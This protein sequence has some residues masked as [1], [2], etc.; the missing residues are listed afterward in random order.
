MASFEADLSGLGGGAAVVFASGFLT[1]SSNQDGEPF[2]I[3]AALAD[4]NV[5]E[6]PQITT[7]RLQVI[8]NAADPA[9]AS[10]DIYL[11]S[12]LL[13]D[14]FA[15]RA[16]SRFVT[17]PANVMLDV[18]VAPGSS[19]SVNDTLKN[20]PVMFAAGGTYVAIANGVL[21]PTQFAANP[22]LSS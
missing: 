6:F 16:A 1:P 21:D 9:A 8:H 3:Y 10:V 17:V 12:A 20:F 13:L 5:V 15:F 7:S 2:G 14:D 11:N 4:G 22:S 19:G 18:G